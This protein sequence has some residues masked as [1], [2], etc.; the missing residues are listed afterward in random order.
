M[1]YTTEVFPATGGAHAMLVVVPD[2]CWPTQRELLDRSAQRHSN[3]LTLDISL[4][5]KPRTLK[6]SRKF[7][8]LVSVLSPI[9]SMSFDECKLFVKMEA[10]ALGYGT[11]I[12]GKGKRLQTIPISE[13]DAST[14]EENMLIETVLKIGAEEGHDLEAEYE[15]R[16][17]GETNDTEES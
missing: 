8:K 16:I 5:H 10:T 9:I 2:A 12:V 14:A 13:A 15:Q 3:Y 1:K 6:G 11:K 7:H 17:E 4:P